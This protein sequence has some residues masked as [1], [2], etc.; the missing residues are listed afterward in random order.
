MMD[1]LLFAGLA[2]LVLGFAGGLTSANER[3]RIRR[4]H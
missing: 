1:T 4:R 2:I 3:F